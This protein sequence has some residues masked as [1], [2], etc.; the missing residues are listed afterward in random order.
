MIFDIAFTQP[1]NKPAEDIE[2]ARAMQ[3]NG[4]VVLAGAKDSIQ[5]LKA[6]YTI[7]EVPITYH[8]RSKFE[9]KKLNWRHGFG[10]IYTLVKYRFVD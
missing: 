7:T 9:G 6:G 4:H 2:L 8:P 3:R 5:G 1:G 10:A